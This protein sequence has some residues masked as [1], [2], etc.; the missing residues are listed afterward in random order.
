MEGVWEELEGRKGRGEV[1]YIYIY[2]LF[3]EN[4]KIFQ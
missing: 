1:I 3:V 4:L 2:I